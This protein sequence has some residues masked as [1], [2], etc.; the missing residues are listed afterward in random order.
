MVQTASAGVSAKKRRRWHLWI[1]LGLVVL[2]VAVLAGAVVVLHRSFQSELT[3]ARG[4]ERE[5]FRRGPPTTFAARRA[6][7]E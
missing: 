4:V 2:L 1:A 6:L 3:Q 7:V 5:T